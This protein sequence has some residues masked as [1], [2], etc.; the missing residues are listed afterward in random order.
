M[1]R[2]LPLVLLLISPVVAVA[3]QALGGIPGPAPS[4]VLSVTARGPLRESLA[5]DS[6]RREIHPTHWKEGGLI[7]GITVGL[8]LGLVVEALCQDSEI[9]GDC[10]GALAGGVL[11][12]GLAGGVV[13]ALIGSLFPKG[14][15]P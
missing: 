4:E 8:G 6:V 1:R 13:G 2:L 9:A 15:D 7:G 11:V 10:R 3:Q 14:E 5:V 12:G